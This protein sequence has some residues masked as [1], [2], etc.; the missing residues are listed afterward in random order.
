MIMLFYGLLMFLPSILGTTGTYD[1]ALDR[2]REASFVASGA[3]GSIDKIVDYQSQQI[4]NE[5]DRNGLRFWAASTAWAYNTIRT[6]TIT[7]IVPVTGLRALASIRGWD[8]NISAGLTWN[9]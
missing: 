8:D 3:K 1:V 7:V 4:E 6:R 5:I 2:A 9:I